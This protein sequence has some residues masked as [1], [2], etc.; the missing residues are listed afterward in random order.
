VE[1]GKLIKSHNSEAKLAQIDEDQAIESRVISAELI[2]RYKDDCE[3]K[4][5][6]KE[7]GQI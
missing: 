7:S 1:V 3:M 6:S 2:K 5:L 4:G